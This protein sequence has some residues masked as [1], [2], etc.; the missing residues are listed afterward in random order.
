MNEI[1]LPTGTHHAVLRGTDVI[2]K[3]PLVYHVVWADRPYG[4]C[5]RCGQAVP[6]EPSCPLSLNP[7]AGLG[8]AI[9]EWDQ[10]HRCG[11]WLAVDSTSLGED[12]SEEQILN[13]AKVLAVG[14][15]DEMQEVRERIRTRLRED[16]R[17]ALA[18]LVEP[19]DT[20]H[21][22]T[23]EDRADEVT[24]GGSEYPGV[25]QDRNQVGVPWVAWDFDPAGDSDTV[26]EVTESSGAGKGT[27]GS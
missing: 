13:A 7:G 21:G 26:I 9:E 8:G 3:E 17:Q 2:T 14:L 5:P 24:T 12:A 20:E 19:L 22:E 18:R 15:A 6:R 16:L 4:K 10:Q 11:E 23:A 27:A 25:F 1:T